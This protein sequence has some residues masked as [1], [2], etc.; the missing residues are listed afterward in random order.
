[1]LIR[2]KN[3]HTKALQISSIVKFKWLDLLV[4]FSARRV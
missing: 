2:L 4:D 3:E 1:M